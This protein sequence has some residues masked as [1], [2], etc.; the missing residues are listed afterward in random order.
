MVENRIYKFGPEC[1]RSNMIYCPTELNTPPDKKLTNVY[2]DGLLAH[3]Y[4]IKVITGLAIQVILSDDFVAGLPKN[5]IMT[6][7]RDKKYI[8]S[9]EDIKKGYQALEQQYSTTIEGFLEQFTMEN[10]VNI[11]FVV[12]RVSLL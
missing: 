7:E 2:I 8:I 6:C 5:Y 4:S 9:E 3:Q 1:L 11:V 12:D 10:P